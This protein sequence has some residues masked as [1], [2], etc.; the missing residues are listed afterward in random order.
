MSIFYYFTVQQSHLFP[1]FSKNT[2]ANIYLRVT[3]VVSMILKKSGKNIYLLA[4]VCC[5]VKFTQKEM[6]TTYD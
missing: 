6:L 3:G 5:Y 1:I 4:W 2:T